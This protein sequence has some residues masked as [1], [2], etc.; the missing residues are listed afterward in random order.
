[1]TKNNKSEIY[2]NKLVDSLVNL[3]IIKSKVIETAF[4]KIPRE[5]FLPNVDLKEV[6]SDSSIITK[7]V[8][9]KP[10]SSSTAPFSNKFMKFVIHLF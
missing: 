8:G 4:R 1:V 9:V 5:L 2:R 3:G 6:Y 10:I 7:V